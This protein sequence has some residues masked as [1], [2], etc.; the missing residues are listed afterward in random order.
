MVGSSLSASIHLQNVQIAEEN[1]GGFPSKKKLD[2]DIGNAVQTPGL[3]AR[4]MGLESMPVAVNERP[5]KAIGCNLVYEGDEELRSGTS[6][7]GKTESRPQ[8]LRKT[9]ELLQRQPVEQDGR[10]RPNVFGKNVTSSCSSINH[11]KLMSPVKS[12]RLLSG[13]HRARLMQ[14]IQRFWSLVRSPE[15][16]PNVPLH[17]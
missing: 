2:A 11:H 17:M 6:G 4:L 15:I 8:K 12:P 7:F 10:V 14:A 9:E 16:V 1:R 5:R 3:V 13:S